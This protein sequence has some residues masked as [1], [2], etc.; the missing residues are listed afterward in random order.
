MRWEHPTLGF[1]PTDKFIS[2]AEQTGMIKDV[3]R[4]CF[5]EVICHLRANAQHLSEELFVC[6]N[7]CATNFEDDEIVVLCSNFQSQLK[8]EKVRLV[9]EITERE[10]IANTI[11]TNSII[12]KL[13]QMGVLFS[14]DDFGTGNANYSYLKQFYP[15]FI[16]VDK[17]FTSNVGT[18]TDTTLVVKNMVSLARKFHCRII[19]EGVEND[20]QLQAL[21]V[22]DVNIFQGYYFSR[23]IPMPNFLDLLRYGLNNHEL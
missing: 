9:L 8:M 23:P 7:I 18:D 10:S 11:E 4:I 17:V 13:R 1:I 19:A 14:L 2:A 15:Y 20:K 12:A 16:K 21:K 5:N 6:F 22:L 3:T